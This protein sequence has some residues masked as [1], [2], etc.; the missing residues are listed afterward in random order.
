MCQLFYTST[1]RISSAVVAP[2]GRG[3]LR[4]ARASRRT[5][6]SGSGRYQSVRAA[7][8]ALAVTTPLKF[9]EDYRGYTERVEA[10]IK[11]GRAALERGVESP[12]R[13]TELDEWKPFREP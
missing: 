12:A 2:R 7:V 8:G 1:R 3:S 6:S 5:A 10:P 13:V 11:V 4:R 9:S